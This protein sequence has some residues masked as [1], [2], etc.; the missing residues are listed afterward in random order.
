MAKTNAEKVKRY[1][2]RKIAELGEEE[3]RRR[4]RERVR[5]Y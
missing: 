4:K 5:K 3:Y 2:A 1:R